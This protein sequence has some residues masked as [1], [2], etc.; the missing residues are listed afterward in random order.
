MGEALD[1]LLASPHYGER[2]GRHWLDVARY[3]TPTAIEHD[4]D[5]PNAW[6]IATTSSGHSTTTS[7]RTVPEEQIA[8]DE[9]DSAP[10][11]AS[12]QPDFCAIMPSAGF[13]RKTI[14]SAATNISTT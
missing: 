14:R 8:G 9:L 2:W 5:R 13:A 11:T 6:R 4:F 7:R 1:R 10:E 3:A 12:S